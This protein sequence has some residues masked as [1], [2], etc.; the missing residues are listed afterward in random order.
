VLVLRGGLLEGEP[1]SDVEVKRLATIP[2]AEVLRAQLVGAVAGPLTTVVGLFA[3]PLRD[4]VNVLDARIAQLQERGEES[5]APESP[6]V[7]S[8]SGLAAAEA[9]GEAPGAEAPSEAPADEAN[10]GPA[11]EPPAGEETPPVESEEE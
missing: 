6:A 4:F 11:Q 10:E 8:E 9:A 2:P 3:A 5:P 7:E 1:V